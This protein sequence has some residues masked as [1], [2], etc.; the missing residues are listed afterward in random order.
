MDER[1][2]GRLRPLLPPQR[3]HVGRPALDHRT[4]LNG[5]LWVLRTGSPWRDVPERYGHWTSVYS[6]F[7]RWTRAGVW[8]R[9][10]QQ[11]QAE[12]QADGEFD[13]TL[14]HMDGSVIRAHQHAAGA[15]GTPQK[16]GPPKRSGAVRAGSQPSSA[17][18]PRDVAAPSPS[19]SYRASA[20]SHSSSRC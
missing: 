1:Q 17:S 8:E 7:K 15:R 5:I 13:W 19:A 10:L 20:T 12:A 11:L 2:W 16:G 3:P 9:V 4:M 14:H 18:A 6:R